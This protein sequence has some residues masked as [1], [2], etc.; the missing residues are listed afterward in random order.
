MGAY[1]ARTIFF[2]L[3]LLTSW[4][5]I[6]AGEFGGADTI[7]NVKANNGGNKEVTL[8]SVLSAAQEVAEREKD[9][10]RRIRLRRSVA[11]FIRSTGQEAFFGNYVAEAMSA[12][13]LDQKAREEKL[14]SLEA[15]ARRAFLGG[16]EARALLL[17]EQAREL[18]S[19]HER[20]HFDVKLESKVQFLAWE[21]EAG[22]MAAGLARLKTS[23]W[24]GTILVLMA[25]RV[26]RAYVVAGQRD[27]GLNILRELL[28]DPDNHSLVAEAF[29]KLGA[30]EE[31]IGIMR[32][33]ARLCFDAAAQDV[34]KPIP[35]Q[36]VQTQLA[37]HDT[38]GALD[39]L[40]RAQSLAA[41]L[42]YDPSPP[43]QPN[44]RTGIWFAHPLK[45]AAQR[46]LL[47]REQLAR[48][49]ARVDL[50]ADAYRLLDEPMANQPAVLAA[51][52]GGQSARGGFAA[53]FATLEMIRDPVRTVPAQY[54][55][56][57]DDGL[58]YP[59]Q[60]SPVA[61]ADDKA[62]SKAIDGAAF[63]IARAAAR[64]G[65]EDAFR[66]AFELGR[67]IDSKAWM[68]LGDRLLRDLAKSGHAKLAM[69]FALEGS[70]ASTQVAALAQVASGM[71]GL[72]DPTEVGWPLNEL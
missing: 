35:L 45:P 49:L 20:A 42:E 8:I 29:W 39:S 11:Y 54:V 63:L 66:R 69:E 36:L 12:A 65:D 70:D 46:W 27:Q 25:Q 16:D 28:S 30:H 6:T 56:N 4:G 41:P 38:E 52:A 68:R 24:Q 58:L 61:R 33:A 26:A 31:A 22:N 55:F 47:V 50:D 32:E 67:E 18:L 51:I 7:G 60:G 10:S 53:A 43:R 64:L 62:R 2:F 21:L 72:P 13:D 3:F 44:V 19:D 37:M 14:R 57:P 23:D 59:P 1:S 9:E 15:E 48:L 5:S 40:R 71:A 17:L 34:K